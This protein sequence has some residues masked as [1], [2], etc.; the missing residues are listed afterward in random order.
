[1]P[2]DAYTFGPKQYHQLFFFS[3]NAG[4]VGRKSFFSFS[5]IG[6]FVLSDICWSIC[7]IL[8]LIKH[9]F[10]TMSKTA[11]AEFF[12]LRKSK[13][14]INKNSNIK[15]G[16][17]STHLGRELKQTMTTNWYWPWYYSK[18]P[19]MKHPQK[20]MVSCSL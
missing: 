4:G 19:K 3:L 1:M 7:K 14:I 11:E 20:K 13:K 16:F 6:A 5:Q 17:Q 15:T 9:I 10:V 8:C 18:K 12:N 2:P